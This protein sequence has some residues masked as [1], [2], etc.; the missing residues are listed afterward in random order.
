MAKEEAEEAAV[1]EDSAAVEE[2]EE[3]A[4]AWCCTST[5]TTSTAL[6]RQRTTPRWWVSRSPWRRATR[7][8]SSRC[9]PRPRRRAFAR[10]MASARAGVLRSTPCGAWD[11]WGC[12][13]AVGV[14]RG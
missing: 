9:P 2:V 1:E 8:A 6:W 12:P 14:A 13:S 4:G 5:S 7:E 3:E 10:A 11:R